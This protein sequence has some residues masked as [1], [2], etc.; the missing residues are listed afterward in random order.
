MD[1]TVTRSEILRKVNEIF[2][3]RNFHVIESMALA[4]EAYWN[5]I[6]FDLEEHSRLRGRKIE[7]RRPPGR[8]QEG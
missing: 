1:I 4:V 8:F 3:S 7:D 5:V 6:R 2:N